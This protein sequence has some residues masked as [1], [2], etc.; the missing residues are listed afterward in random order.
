LRAA[1]VHNHALHPHKVGGGVT[2]SIVVSYASRDTKSGAVQLSVPM[3]PE[4]TEEMIASVA[5]VV[6]SNACEETAAVP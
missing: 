4:L 6:R 3:Y 5:S 1:L 2:P